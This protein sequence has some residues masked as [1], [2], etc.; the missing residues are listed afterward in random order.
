MSRK[1]WPAPHTSTVDEKKSSLPPGMCR[2]VHVWCNMFSYQA[3]DQ[4]YLSAEGHWNQLKHR[5]FH[6]WGVGFSFQKKT[7]FPDSSSG[8]F[9]N[10]FIRKDVTPASRTS[11]LRSNWCHA[12]L[13]VLSTLWT[14]CTLEPHFGMGWWDG[15]IR[16]SR[17]IVVTSWKFNSSP[18]NISH[19]KRKGLSSS[20]IHFRP[21][22]D[23]GG[24]L[25]EQSSS[26]SDEYLNQNGLNFALVWRY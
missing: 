10:F 14:L 12:N 24:E 5:V 15:T 6:F 19:L 11:Y 7:Y 3:S 9:G 13:V 20:N 23:I 18:L 22:N 4:R 25:G 26:Y 2:V 21:A 1:W 8:R 17:N 16:F